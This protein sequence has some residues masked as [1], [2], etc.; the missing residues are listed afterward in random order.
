M[1][2]YTSD[3]VFLLLSS[4]WAPRSSLVALHLFVLDFETRNTCYF[5][6]DI[7][8]L[9][10]SSSFLSARPEIWATTLPVLRLVLVILDLFVLQSPKES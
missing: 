3:N 5:L 2:T 9:I 8:S 10:V 4:S 7:S 1:V 6:G